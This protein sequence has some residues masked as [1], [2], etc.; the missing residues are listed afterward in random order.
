[1]LVDQK[2]NRLTGNARKDFLRSKGTGAILLYINGENTN[3]IGLNINFPFGNK[4][5]IPSDDNMNAV[6]VIFNSKGTFHSFPCKVNINEF[7]EFTKTTFSAKKSKEES[8]ASSVKESKCTPRM[9]ELREIIR[10]NKLPK[11]STQNVSEPLP[12]LDKLSYLREIIRQN[13]HSLPEAHHTESNILESPEKRK[14]PDVAENLPTSKRPCS[15]V[16]KNEILHPHRNV[17]TRFFAAHKLA[18]YPPTSPASKTFTPYFDSKKAFSFFNSTTTQEGEGRANASMQAK[19]RTQNEAEISQISRQTRARQNTAQ[20]DKTSAAFHSIDDG[21]EINLQK[22]EK[23]KID[24]LSPD[25][26]H[27]NRPSFER[28]N[29]KAEMPTTRNVETRLSSRQKSATLSATCPPKT[30]TP[31][32][33]TKKSPNFF[34]STTK[35]DATRKKNDS[36]QPKFQPQKGTQTNQKVNQAQVAKRQVVVNQ[37]QQR[38]QQQATQQRAQQQA[39]QQRVQQQATQQRV[40]Q[41]ATQQ[42]AQQQVAQQRAQQ[43]AAQQR[44]AQLRAQQ[45][46]AQQRAAQLRAQQQAAQQRAAQERAAREAQQ[47]AAR[48]QAAREAQR[49]AQARAAQQQLAAQR[50][51]EQSRLAYQRASWQRAATTAAAFRFRR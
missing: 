22:T 11:S 21:D 35:Q 3:E 14:T 28:A 6:K 43:Q 25:L 47:R 19:S 45:Q 9:L 32:F 44:A 5:R 48:E 37:T 12:T 50:A 26:P 24:E 39:T 41:Q 29:N 13:K 2:G 1:V 20:Q 40:Q 23:R 18:N 46:A 33:D 30:Y 42:R 27:N 31:H 16:N 4:P 17:E 7:P 49:A 51:A 34:N 8:G 36:V 38:T 15:E 10:N